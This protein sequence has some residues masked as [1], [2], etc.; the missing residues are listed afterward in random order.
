MCVIS[1]VFLFW[2]ALVHDK[3][4][5]FY[6]LI[7]NMK[8]NNENEPI[9]TLLAIAFVRDIVIWVFFIALKWYQED[10]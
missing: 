8:L 7:F 3:M 2:P 5:T 6:L 10:R 9:L 1:D 4:I